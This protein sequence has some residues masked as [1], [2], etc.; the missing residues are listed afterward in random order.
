[1]SP[2]AT[3]VT[4]AIRQPTATAAPEP[5]PAKAAAKTA[6]RMPWQI[7]QIGVELI[8][9]S[10][11][12]PRL[13]FDPSE[14]AELAASVRERGVQMPVLVRTAKPEP[15]AGSAHANGKS[16]NGH[17]TSKRTRCEKRLR[18]EL[19]AGERRLRACKEAGRKQIPA[20]AMSRMDDVPPWLDVFEL[21]QLLIW[22]LNVKPVNWGRPLHWRYVNYDTRLPLHR[23]QAVR[24][25][26]ALCTEQ[27]VSPSDAADLI[28]LTERFF[29]AVPT[30]RTGGIDLASIREGAAR[31]QVAQELGLAEDREV[32]EA[33]FPAMAVVYGEIHSSLEDLVREMQL[34]GLRAV[35]TTDLDIDDYR[36]SVVRG[37]PSAE[38]TLYSVN[39]GTSGSA[40]FTFRFEA[41]LVT[42]SLEK[43]YS[44]PK[45]PKGT[46]IFTLILQRDAN[47][48]RVQFPHQEKRLT[49]EADGQ[50]SLRGMNMELLRVITVPEVVA[51][52]KKWIEDPEAW[53]AIQ[54][55]R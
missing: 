24:A 54:R 33:S 43:H 22:M 6:A 31:G 28:G 9:P 11:Y 10:P 27:S 30:E 26:T 4:D 1:M 8:D 7:V 12:Q 5:A 13:S 32:V 38:Q 52:I 53:E 15:E 49:L 21:S 19:I 41:A 16:S 35:E 50:L 47:L 2:T 29:P 42:P 46:N 36:A 48:G 18:Y 40:Q 45:P 25:V 44:G 55:D 20:I 17:A 37:Y 39:C 3:R 34:R 14:T 51:M 23:V